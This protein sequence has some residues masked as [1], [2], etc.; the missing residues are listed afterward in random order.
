MKHDE[1][2]GHV[3]NRARLDSRGAAERATRATLET[4]GERLS[5][6]MATNLAAQLPVEIGEHLRR[7]ASG[8]GDQIDL[9]DFFA[10]VQERIGGGVDTPQAVF[11]AR[12]VM[13]VVDEATTGG[14]LPKVKEQLPDEFERLFSAGSTGRMPRDD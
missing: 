3:Q 13:E 4:L 12:C 5:E 8:T 1:F 6:G 9:G 7:T 11:Y 2:I 10:R 14:L